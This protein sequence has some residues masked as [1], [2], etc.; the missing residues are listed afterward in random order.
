M[1]EIEIETD[2]YMYEKE[3]V[4]DLENGNRT[5]GENITYVAISPDGSIVATFNPYNNY[6]I[7][8]HGGVLTFLKNS[9]NSLKNRVTLICMNCVKI[10]KINI[11]LNKNISI[12][13]EGSTYLLPENLFKKLESFED[14]RCNWKYLLKSKFQEYLMVDT[15]ANGKVVFHNKFFED[16]FKV[17]QEI[18]LKR[19][20]FGE[21]DNATESTDEHEYKSC[22]LEP[23]NNSTK[24]I[25][26][27]NYGNLN[28]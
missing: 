19:T 10:Q 16:Q 23:W 25:R 28:P 12:P 24:A 11:K 22:D 27:F 9:K 14:S 1:D 26:V 3:Y 13:K 18:T 2:K 20:T 4:D 7:Q 5:Y 8:H 17:V 21:N 6:L 15:R